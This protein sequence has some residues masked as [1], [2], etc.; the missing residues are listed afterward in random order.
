MLSLS[1]NN[2]AEL[3]KRGVVI[4]DLI[5]FEVRSRSDGSTVTEGYWSDI[6][7]AGLNVIDPD[8][9]SGVARTFKGAG[10]LVKIEAI[11]RVSN[12]SITKVDVSISG[13]QNGFDL[14]RNYDAKQARVTIWRSFFSKGMVQVDPAFVKFDGY[15]DE[16]PVPIGPK[17]QVNAIELVVSS[18]TQELQRTNHATRS[19]QFQRNRSATDTFRRHKAT[20]GDWVLDWGE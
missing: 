14:I 5:W 16:A 19:D 20:A 15:L 1:T 17:G 10:Q 11:P 9:G 13:I 4:R 12:L 3:V 7:E 18:H 6:G 8:T 2:A